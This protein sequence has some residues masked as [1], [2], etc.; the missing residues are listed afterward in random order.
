MNI[1]F[2]PTERDTF[3]RCI[4]ITNGIGYDL[5]LDFS[6]QM[7]SMKRQILKLVGFFG[8]IATSF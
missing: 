5:V 3:Q 6:G 7:E 1:V 8:V 4:E 2:T